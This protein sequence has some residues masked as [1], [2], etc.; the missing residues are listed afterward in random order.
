MKKLLILFA[1][2]IFLVGCSGEYDKTSSIEVLE[3]SDNII[4]LKDRLSTDE[5]NT[6]LRNNIAEQMF[7]LELETAKIKGVNEENLPFFINK[8][9]NI[10]VLLVHGFTAT[11]WEVRELGDFLA[12]KGYNV[13]GTLLE[14]HGTNITDLKKTKWE[15]W[16]DDVKNADEALSYISSKVFVV[17]V[18][19]G[20]SLG[21]MLEEDSY[22]ADGIV[23]LACPIYMTQKNLWLVPT[24]KYFYWYQKRNISDEDK[25]HYYEYRPLAS[26]Q[27]LTQLIK[28]SI[29]KMNNMDKPILIVQ[30]KDDKTVDPRSA[31]FIYNNIHSSDKKL[32][33]L[34]GDYHVLTKGENRDEVFAMVN[35]FIEEHSK[36]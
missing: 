10:S 22:K 31:D 9:S 6:Q 25:L 4:S 28:S 27:Q 34:E 24:I 3:I 17:G 18:S 19:T 1:L 7:E 35:T 26:V 12:A 20:G 36:V 11:P 33:Y 13:Y 5:K 23:C 30:N 15:D 29:Q 16:Y 8:G 2:S 21:I 14:G 32:I